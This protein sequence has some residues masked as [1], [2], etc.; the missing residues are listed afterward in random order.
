MLENLNV[1]F[2]CH[3]TFNCIDLNLIRLLKP[4]DEATRHL[5]GEKASTL[6]LVLPSKM[7]L[8][9]S[10]APQNDDGDIVK[11]VRYSFVGSK[12]IFMFVV[13]RNS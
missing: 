8:L 1:K 12:F 9:R 6:Y 7:T 11:E 4:F 10:L 13:Y 5:S 2:S 3:R